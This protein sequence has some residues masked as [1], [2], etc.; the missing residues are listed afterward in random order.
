MPSNRDGQAAVQQYLACFL[1]APLRLAGYPLIISGA[2]FLG[3]NPLSLA[4]I[5]KLASQRSVEVSLTIIVASLTQFLVMSS[6]AS[7]ALPLLRTC[8]YTGRIITEVANRGFA[9]S[10]RNLR[11]RKRFPFNSSC[12]V[13]DPN[14][15]TQVLFLA[16]EKVHPQ[17][18]MTSSPRFAP[19]SYFLDT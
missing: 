9:S 12:I 2:L 17:N 11:Q 4:E 15:G 19:R 1:A 18:S 6:L 5:R 3:V 13:G 8:Q 16:S 10:S 7:N 14:N